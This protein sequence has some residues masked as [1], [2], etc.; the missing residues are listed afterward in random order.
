V[1]A[2]PRGPTRGAEDQIDTRSSHSVR[3]QV[4]L[5]NQKTQGSLPPRFGAEPRGTAVWRAGARAFSLRASAVAPPAAAV[6]RPPG[7]VFSSYHARRDDPDCMPSTH[8]LAPQSQTA[9]Q[10]GTGP[11]TARGYRSDADQFR[12][13]LALLLN[14]SFSICQAAFRTTPDIAHPYHQ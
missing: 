5:S 6:T 2:P 3:N 7:P 12:H 1:I 8:S 14:P 9:R 10:S 13:S 4:S 11:R